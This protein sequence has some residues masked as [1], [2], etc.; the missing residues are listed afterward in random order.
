VD[1]EKKEGNAADEADND[2]DGD[3]NGDD[4]VDKGT[5]IDVLPRSRVATM[6]EAEATRFVRGRDL[7]RRVSSAR[8]WSCCCALSC[9]L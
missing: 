1:S 3:R 2:E 5:E 4:G 6:R 9:T 8:S 7:R